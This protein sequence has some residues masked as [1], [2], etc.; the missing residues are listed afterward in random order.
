MTLTNHQK[1]VLDKS[2]QALHRPTDVSTPDGNVYSV[3]LAVITGAGGVGKTTTAKGIA[4]RWR[5]TELLGNQSIIY[6]APTHKAKNVLSESVNET[7]ITVQSLLGNKIEIQIVDDAPR[8]MQVAGNK[9]KSVQ[10]GTLIVIDEASMV[11]KRDLNNI[12]RHAED[13]GFSILFLGDYYQLPPMGD[14]TFNIFRCININMYELKENHRAESKDLLIVLD[15]MRR[16]IA[17]DVKI[18]ISKYNLKTTD[19][20]VDETLITY[21]KANALY[22]N[23]IKTRIKS[24]DTIILDDMTE[25][26]S[27]ATE[28]KVMSAKRTRIS[29]KFTITN[30]NNGEVYV[31]P[32]SNKTTKKIFPAFRAFQEDMEMKAETRVKLESIEDTANKIRK[33]LVGY[34]KD[35]GINVHKAQGS[36]YD[37]VV[38]KISDFEYMLNVN[39]IDIETYNRAVYTAFSRAKY[40]AKIF[41]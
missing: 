27:N 17:N 23:G 7:A 26:Y 19:E 16:C 20:V 24:G 37:D 39:F 5:G 41:K 15:D 32:A 34:F 33:N 4:D 40:S 10:S 18:D 25:H 3:K 6:A 35:N 2:L 8:K 21:I 38:V 11:G 13:K 14:D 29:D 36:T 31:Y 28:L 12:F 22:A 30:I 1:A 9:L